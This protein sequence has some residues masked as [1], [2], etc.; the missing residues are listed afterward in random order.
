ML[1]IRTNLRKM[2]TIVAC[3]AVTTM[4]ASCGKN[5]DDGKGRE[6]TAVEKEL[7]GTWFSGA[8][9][10]LQFRDDGTYTMHSYLGV[11]AYP[12]H[13]MIRGNWRLSDGVISMT[14]RK[15][16]NWEGTNAPPKDLVW[17]GISD[18][19]MRIRFDKNNLGERAIVDVDNDV[20]YSWQDSYPDWVVF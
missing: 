12:S 17:K 2:A 3:L 16:T 10:Y 9:G 20:M 6:L 19:S 4:F 7:V 5:G 15:Q 1:K 14:Q 8:A 13:T 11:Y 18:H